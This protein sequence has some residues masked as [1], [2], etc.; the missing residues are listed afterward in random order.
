M[1]LHRIRLGNTVFEGRNNAYLLPGEETTLVDAGASL[2]E[3]R[4]DLDAGLDEAGLDVTDIDQILLT[5]WH[6]D[7]AGLAGELQAESGAVVRAHEADAPLV[8]GEESAVSAERD[9][10]QRRFEEWGV[11]DGKRAELAG[12]LDTHEDLEGEPADVVSMTDGD[13]LPAGDGEL[14]VVHLPG[15]A[16]GLVAFAFEA[17]GEGESGEA[18]E[19]AFVGD[20]IL[21]KYTPNVGGAD[22]RVERPLQTYVDSLL[23]LVDRDLSRAFPGHRDPIEDPS[24]RA[25][26]ILDHHRDRTRRVVDVL[27]EH[28]PLDA[29]TVSARLFGELE[30]IH[31]L[32]GPGE[33]WAHLD[34]LVHAD[35]AA[36]D[37]DEYRLV[38]S[39]P[40]VSAL[41]PE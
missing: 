28:G 18:T 19:R 15:H 36:R 5:H 39:D 9:L 40:D 35:V 17:D 13:R 14:E 12:Y 21:P 23:A 30:N 31:I 26:T 38:E 33:A 4:A 37:G 8:A 11:P 34:H 7:H 24:D 20:A 6:A 10:R 1:D 3:I 29:W 27:D 2:G 16:A 41:F 32:H 25:L 22:L